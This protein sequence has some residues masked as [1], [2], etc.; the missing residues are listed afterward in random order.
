MSDTEIPSIQPV[1]EPAAEV[2][3]APAKKARAKKPRMTKAGKP[4]KRANNKP[5]ASNLT[6][7][8]ETLKLFIERGKQAKDT[9][10]DSESELELPDPLDMSPTPVEPPRP[11]TPPPR[12]PTP[13][14]KKAKKKKKI[15]IE[16]DSSSSEEE[17]IHYKPKTASKPSQGD[18]IAANYQLKSEL[19]K[20]RSE[21]ET[22][23]LE[24]EKRLKN[25]T[26]EAFL[27]GARSR[28][29]LKF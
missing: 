19:E 29:S 25:N 6:K 7:A 16:D 26:D 17:V 2:A 15:V 14:P 11:P 1:A 28:I 27:L 12:P 9:K 24:T 3:V 23:K 20:I 4:D 18:Y 8:R 13:P 10:D 21:F 5:P 22:H